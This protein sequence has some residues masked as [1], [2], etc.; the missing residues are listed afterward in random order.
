MVWNGLEYVEVSFDMKKLES[1][2]LEAY[3][4]DKIRNFKKISNP[5]CDT[6][7]FNERGEKIT[8]YYKRGKDDLEIF[9]SP[10][11]HPTNGKTLDD[12]TRHMIQQHICSQY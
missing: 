11:I 2:E 3:N 5:D 9:T 4:A 7:Y 12:I 6:E 8:W 10:G 1:G